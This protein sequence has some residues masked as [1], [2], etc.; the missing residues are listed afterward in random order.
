[1]KRFLNKTKTMI[2]RINKVQV[3]V[4][5]LMMNLLIAVPA[6]AAPNPGVNLASWFQTQILPIAGVIMIGAIVKYISKKNVVAIV[7]TVVLGGLVMVF[8]NDPEF[9]KTIAEWLLNITG[10]K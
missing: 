4:M 9:A 5:G 10:L 1:M 3:L 8:I 2:E 6:Y 7:V